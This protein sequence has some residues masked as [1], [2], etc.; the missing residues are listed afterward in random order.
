MA[1]ITFPDHGCTTGALRHTVQGNSTLAPTAAGISRS[2]T[3][4]TYGMITRPRK[5]L[6][7]QAQW[8]NFMRWYLR[9]GRHHRWFDITWPENGQTEEARFS[10]NLDLSAVN[11]V[12]DVYELDIEFEQRTLEVNYVANITP[13]PDYEYFEGSANDGFILNQRRT[14]FEWGLEDQLNQDGS[15][16][17]QAKRQVRMTN[18]QFQT[19]EVW[20]Q[21]LAARL[22]WFEMLW[23]DGS[24][25]NPVRIK[26]GTYSAETV[27]PTTEHW[28]VDMTFEYFWQD[29][30]VL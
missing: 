8:D 13:F 3:R 5:I 6:F 23:N 19:F 24:T 26:D 4:Y 27:G 15:V 20:F 2:M 11:R 9:D 17:T 22:H 12:G 14:D 28:R 10:G 7:S 18:A 1:D 30:V 16:F 25:K 29:G 21:T